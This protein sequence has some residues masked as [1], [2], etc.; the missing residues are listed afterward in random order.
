MRW[1]GC[2]NGNRSPPAPRGGTYQLQHPRAA[3]AGGEAAEGAQQHHD[4][5]GAHQDKG[6][7]GG[8][9]IQQREVDGQAHPAPHAHGQQHDARYL[10]RREKAALSR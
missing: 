9:L 4:D 3:A 8:F 5:A 1:V 7:V 6:H 10:R 2:P